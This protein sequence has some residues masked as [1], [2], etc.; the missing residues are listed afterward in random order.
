[1]PCG[2]IK[3]V[4]VNQDQWVLRLVVREGIYRG[5]AGC[6]VVLSRVGAEACQGMD[7]Q[8]T[9]AERWVLL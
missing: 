5:G 1:M 2:V 3:P 8:K 7:I 6:H 9:S 4:L